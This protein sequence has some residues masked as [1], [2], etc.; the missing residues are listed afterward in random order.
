MRKLK[1][2][3]LYVRYLLSIYQKTDQGEAN[4]ICFSHDD[5][6][7]EEKELIADFSDHQDDQEKEEVIHPVQ[8][9]EKEMP[10]SSQEYEEDLSFPSDIFDMEEEEKPVPMK[11]KSYGFYDHVMIVVFIVFV[12][13]VILPFY[14]MD[15]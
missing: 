9:D 12:M 3:E 10:S 8:E 14:Q 7:E 13:R 11:N 4:P 5:Q 15:T 6:E 2:S 1:S